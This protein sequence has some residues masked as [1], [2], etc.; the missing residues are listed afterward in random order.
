MFGY[1]FLSLNQLHKRKVKQE[2]SFALN[3]VTQLIKPAVLIQ[4]VDSEFAHF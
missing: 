4:R 2:L 1:L 3:D